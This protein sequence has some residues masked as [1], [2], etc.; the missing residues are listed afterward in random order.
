MNHYRALAL[1]AL[2]A[3][4]LGCSQNPMTETAS[5]WQCTAFAENNLGANRLYSWHDT[6]RTVAVNNALESCRRHDS[7]AEMCRVVVG[8]CEP[9]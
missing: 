3:I 5:A 2:G 6:N 4:L 8:D 1:A 9:Y 7:N